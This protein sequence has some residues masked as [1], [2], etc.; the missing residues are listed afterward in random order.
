MKFNLSNRSY[1][2]IYS[3]AITANPQMDTKPVFFRRQDLAHLHA[4]GIEDAD[5]ALALGMVGVW[6]HDMDGFSGGKSQSKMD[7][8]L[9]YPY[10]LGN[11][12]VSPFFNDISI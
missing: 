4:S 10:D 1:N 2:P 3:R 5:E 12:H 8:C 6:Y 7:D 9:G 11:L